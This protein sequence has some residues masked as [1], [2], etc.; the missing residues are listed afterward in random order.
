MRRGYKLLC[1]KGAG[2]HR[3][4]PEKEESFCSMNV[5]IVS[6]IYNR[7]FTPMLRS[8]FSLR[9]LGTLDIFMPWCGYGDGERDSRDIITEKYNAGRARVLSGAYDA[10][11]CIESDMIVPEDALVK[12]A[13]TGADVAYGVYVFRRTPWAWSAYS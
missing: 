5:L 11:L 2:Q 3:A 7:L 4:L 6:P 9:A 8:V 12:L 13:A 10:M 1:R